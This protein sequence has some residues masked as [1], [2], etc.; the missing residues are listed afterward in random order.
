MILGHS[1]FAGRAKAPSLGDD[2]RQT[3][4]ITGSSR[5]D[6]RSVRTL[7]FIQFH[8]PLNGAAMQNYSS[9]E[10]AID[11]RARRAA[12]RVGLIARKSRRR[13]GSCDNHGGFMLVTES[14]AIRAGERFDLSADEVIEYCSSNDS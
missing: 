12:K 5:D 9:D 10:S 14:N 4:G 13:V 8:Q 6:A 1:G 2:A 11:A 7:R 3:N